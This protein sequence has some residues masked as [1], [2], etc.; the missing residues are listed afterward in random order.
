MRGLTGI[1]MPREAHPVTAA[2]DLPIADPA[3]DTAIR[4]GLGLVEERLQAAVRQADRLA[5]SAS[6]HLISAGGKRVRP[7]LTLLAAHLGDPGR[8][9]VLDAAVVVELTHLATLYHD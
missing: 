1:V 6:K 4:E 3:F 8:P 9:A 7:M 5:D 2:L